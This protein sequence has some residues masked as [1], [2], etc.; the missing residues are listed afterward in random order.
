MLTWN[1]LTWSS[2]SRS[3]LFKLG[4]SLLFHRYPNW[5]NLV[6]AKHRSGLIFHEQFRAAC[7]DNLQRNLNWERISGS[8]KSNFN[9]SL[10][11]KIRIARWTL[12]SMHEKVQRCKCV[13]VK[14]VK[15]KSISKYLHRELAF[16]VLYRR[17]FDAEF[18][19]TSN[20]RRFRVIGSGIQVRFDF[21][22]VCRRISKETVSLL[23]VRT[24]LKWVA[25]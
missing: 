21:K 13:G 6:Q 5:K 11:F 2:R 7:A 3:P 23:R 15:W 4:D 10:N 12:T 19:S 22:N 17:G 24:K 9:K 20:L 8:E 25:R 14:S 18:G 16:Y 1:W